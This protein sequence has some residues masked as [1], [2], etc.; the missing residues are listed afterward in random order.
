MSGWLSKA[1]KEVQAGRYVLRL[2]EPLR[3]GGC[4]LTHRTGLLIRWTE[5]GGGVGWGEASPLPGYHRESLEEVIQAF[6]VWKRDPEAWG[7]AGDFPSLRFGLE[8]AAESAGGRFAG[9]SARRIG[10][11]ALVDLSRPGEAIARIAEGYHRLKIKVGRMDVEVERE[12]LRRIM[13]ELPEGVRLR[14]DANGSL[15]LEAALHLAEGLEG[16]GIDYFEEPVAEAGDLERFR[17]ETGWPVALDE[18]MA[19]EEPSADKLRGVDALVCKPMRAG[20]FSRARGWKACCEAAGT[21]FVLSSCFESGV[22]LGGLLD[23]AAE[24]EVSE[25]CG[26]DTW[27]IFGQDVV[28]PRL[29]LDGPEVMWPRAGD[30]MRIDESM[31]EWLDD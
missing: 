20:G 12:G 25:P 21:R 8:Q 18:S 26:F 30:G 28:T 1:A 17:R 27:R 22:G 14:L 16:D 31:V 19:D 2:G 6:G 15:S 3:V 9:L 11:N 7:L 24:V 29:E 10:I 4:E 5:D 13:G 23:L